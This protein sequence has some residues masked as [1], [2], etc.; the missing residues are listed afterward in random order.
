ML[1]WLKRLHD[2][3]AT[4]VEGLL[5]TW[6]DLMEG[7]ERGEREKFFDEV[8]A[9]AKKAGAISL[10]FFFKLTAFTSLTHSQDR[11]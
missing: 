5:K 1:A 4:E 8:V 7:K 9:L 11:R 10:N 3:Q 6:H 2:E